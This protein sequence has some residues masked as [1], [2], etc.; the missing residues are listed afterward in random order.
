M[1]E[2]ERWERLGKGRERERERERVSTLLSLIAVR[3]LVATTVVARPVCFVH[4]ECKFFPKPDN[5]PHVDCVCKKYQ[6]H[7]SIAIAL[8]SKETSDGT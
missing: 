6:G 4:I 3:R 5:Y 7:S 8:H 2:K 1:G